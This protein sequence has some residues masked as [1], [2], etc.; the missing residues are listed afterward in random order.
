MLLTRHVHKKMY[1]VLVH[2]YIYKILRIAV[3]INNSKYLR[4]DQNR[5]VDFNLLKK[6]LQDSKK[7][8]THKLES[9]F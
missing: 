9:N 6:T 3:Q 8:Y 4:Y 1:I 7:D 2:I 5:I